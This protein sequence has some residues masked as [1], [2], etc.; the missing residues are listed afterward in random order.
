MCPPAVEP[1]PYHTEFVRLSLLRCDEVLRAALADVRL[2]LEEVVS[3][4]Q[5]VNT[6]VEGHLFSRSG[7]S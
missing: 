7:H 1:A 5:N 6:P 4:P 2:R 3:P